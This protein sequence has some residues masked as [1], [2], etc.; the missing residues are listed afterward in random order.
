MDQ[1][2]ATGKH[3]VDD[4]NRDPNDPDPDDPDRSTNASKER[5]E[6]ILH[7][8]AEGKQLRAKHVAEHFNCSIP[9]AKR[10]LQALKRDGKIE[11]VGSTRSG[12]YRL[13]QV[14]KSDR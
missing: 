8:M 10:D 13:C 2:N 3:G 6:W 12:D 7:R 5:R 14:S 1:D 4:P 9:T 11:F